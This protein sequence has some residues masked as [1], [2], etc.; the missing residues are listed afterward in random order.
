[1][2]NNF[3]DE[4][5][6][7]AEEKFNKEFEQIRERSDWF[8]NASPVDIKQFLSAELRLLATEIKK[9]MKMKEKY[10]YPDRNTDYIYYRYGYNQAI[11]EINNKLDNL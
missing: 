7:R 8:I 10:L 2:T 1:M 3:L 5:I 11:E 9:E 4:F 6:A